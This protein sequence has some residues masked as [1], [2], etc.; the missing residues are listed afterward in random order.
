MADSATHCG[1]LIRFY[2]RAIKTSACDVVQ[3]ESEQCSD[4]EKKQS[5]RNKMKTK[6]KLNRLF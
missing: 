1:M 4:V 5:R 2:V 6:W 3:L